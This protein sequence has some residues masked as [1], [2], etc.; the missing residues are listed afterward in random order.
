MLRHGPSALVGLVIFDT[1][2]SRL[3]LCVKCLVAID[4]VN[5][6]EEI[7]A[8]E[9]RSCAAEAELLLITKLQV[10]CL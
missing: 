10:D 2:F 4:E 7:S 5:R 3:S 1:F 6:Q 9:C 8:A